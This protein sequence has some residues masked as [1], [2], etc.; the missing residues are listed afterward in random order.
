M[1][2]YRCLPLRKPDIKRFLNS[3]NRHFHKAT[4][5]STTIDPNGLPASSK[6]EIRVGQPHEARIYTPWAGHWERNQILNYATDRHRTDTRYEEAFIGF[7][8]HT[9]SFCSQF[10]YAPKYLMFLLMHLYIPIF[11]L[12]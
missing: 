2:S 3:R 9:K 11:C 10:V 4:A 8:P 12:Y 1:W 7:G 6:T 5:Q